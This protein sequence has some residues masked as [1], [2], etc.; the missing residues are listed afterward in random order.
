MA[1]Q[2]LLK[3]ADLHKRFGGVQAVDGASFEVAQG[4]IYGLI[5]PNGSG[6]TT[7]FN[8][9]TG[10]LG[11]DSGTVTFGGQGVLGLRPHQV[12]RRGLA[13]T[14]QASL[15]PAEMTVMENMLLAP[16]SQLGEDLWRAAMHPR[17]VRAQEAANLAQARETLALV[18][19]EHM[20]DELV[21]SLSGGQKKLLSLAQAL[22]AGPELICLDE[23]VAGVNPRL[24]DDIVAVILRLR[25]EGRATFL[26]VEHNM[27]VV[28][29]LCDRL[30]VLDAGDTIA[31]GEPRATLAREDVLQAYLGGRRHH[32]GAA[33]DTEA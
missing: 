33:T 7:V 8:L 27:T 18:G 15:N 24:I 31:S 2:T 4:E 20:R 19:M 10:F 1:P 22:M 23:P 17:R 11:A 25:D 5:G 30:S 32:A 14:F 26:V 29:R 9:L 6:K 21:G 13:R 28:R 3:V 16:G 12:A